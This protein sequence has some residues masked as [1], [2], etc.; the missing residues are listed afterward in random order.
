M[1]G[2]YENGVRLH[3]IAPEKPIQNC[4][5]KSFNGKRRTGGRRGQVG[6]TGGRQLSARPLLSTYG[7]NR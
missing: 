4:F 6:L 1:P 7:N 2:V 3:S 5:V